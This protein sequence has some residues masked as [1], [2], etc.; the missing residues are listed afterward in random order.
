MRNAGIK[1]VDPCGDAYRLKPEPNLRG[2]L[3]SS[4]VH[5][6][7][8]TLTERNPGVRKDARARS[9]RDITRVS[10]TLS[11]S[12]ILG[13]RTTLQTCIDSQG[14]FLTAISFKFFQFKRT[15]IPRAARV[16]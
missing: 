12:S 5:P 9:E 15:R 3:P 16:F 2:D 7:P 14:L 11:P 6:R 10:G 1:R 4:I 8:L 13:G